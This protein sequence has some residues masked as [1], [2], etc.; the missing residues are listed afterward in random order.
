MRQA[1]L[2]PTATCAAAPG[3]SAVPSWAACAAVMAGMAGAWLAAGS[4]G[5]LTPTLRHAATWLA[6]GVAGIAGWPRKP[7]AGRRLLA[8]VGGLIA[9]AV[10]TL[11]T[12]TLYNLLAVAVLLAALAWANEG[13]DQRLLVLGAAAVAVLGVYRLVYTSVP[14]LWLVANAVAGWCGGAMGS[15]SGRPLAVGATLAGLDFLVLMAAVWVGWLLVASPRAP[16][17][18]LAAVAVVAGHGAYLFVLAWADDLWAWL[19]TPPPPPE[20]MLYTPPPWHWSDALRQLLP[21]NLPLAA[22]AVQ[23]A[24]AAAMFR[25]VPW[26]S[27]AAESRAARWQPTLLR[28]APVRALL[29]PGAR[30]WVVLVALAA[31]IPALAC[32][33]GR[34]VDLTGRKILAYQKGNLDWDKPVFGRYGH[35]AAG[36]YGLLPDLLTS[37]GAEFARSDDL[38]ADEL[39]RADVLVVIHPVEPWSE[40]QRERVWDFVRGGGALL[41][42]AGPRVKEDQDPSSVNQLLEPT[43]MQVRFDTVI[44]TTSNWEH[45]CEALPHPATTGLEAGRHSF[46]LLMGSS[47]LAGWPARPVLVGRC[48]WSDPG[49]DAM[50]TGLF[51]HEPG[52]P[53]GDLVLAAEQRLGR[54][55]VFVLADPNSL[56]NEAIPHSYRFA[57][58]LFGYLAAR[59]ASPQAG[60]RQL[61]GLVASLGLLG[62][63]ACGPKPERLAAAAGAMALSLAVCRLASDS[64]AEVLPQSAPGA[65]GNIAYLD[66]SH[67]E[68]YVDAAWAG[69]GIAG[70]LL[71][72][73]RSGYLPLLLPQFSQEHLDRAGLLISIG[74]ARAFSA[75]ERAMVMAFVERGGAFVSMVGAEHAAASQPLLEDLGFRVPPSPVLAGQSGREP[76]P[77]GSVKAPYIF[78]GQS[79]AHLILHAG[80]P[81]ECKGDRTQIL[82]H[83]GD[84]AEAVIDRMGLK[85][86]V[87]STADGGGPYTVVAERRI[88]RGRVVVIGDTEFAMNKNLENP[89]GEPFFGGYENAHFWRWL[90]T[91]LKGEPEWIPPDSP[92]DQPPPDAPESPPPPNKDQAARAVGPGKAV[93]EAAP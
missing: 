20:Q 47:I 10:L 23:L 59:G 53:W 81:I 11:P 70:L 76:L 54:G 58:R 66:A 89:G 21:W 80:W 15:L 78:S 22:G 3:A 93:E 37:L 28:F 39:A 71:T 35:L 1:T 12:L 43:A 42:V 75:S 30:G 34:H 50:V 62:L 33:S 8:L 74:P 4:T 29:A 77:L 55:T 68:A 41:L 26:P 40:G 79:Q 14:T 45:A 32:L 82:S 92:P 90:L 91:R 69:D 83:I 57:G 84:L 52:E 87:Q 64:S 25:R 56:A 13:A 27:G 63:L 73:M 46:G 85:R 19:P 72:L 18:A 16:H 6:L 49:S 2:A 86:P 88:G 7:L 48:G 60:W 44:S 17:A 65:T 5:L 51:R 61:L 38:A 31:A 9:A 67:A 24:V 36:G